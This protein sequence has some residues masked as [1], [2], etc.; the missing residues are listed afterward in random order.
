MNHDQVKRMIDKLNSDRDSGRINED[1]Y[2]AGLSGIEH[3]VGT[4]GYQP[5]NIPETCSI[6]GIR[7][8]DGEYLDSLGKVG[9]SF[10]KA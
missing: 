8:L 3:A 10:R 1:Q 4:L 9:S 6:T 7:T 2:A 5:K